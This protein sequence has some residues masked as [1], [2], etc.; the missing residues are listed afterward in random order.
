MTIQI[1]I[2]STIATLK[3]RHE[4]REAMKELRTFS[5]KA[6]QDIGIGRCEIER[7]VRFPLGNGC[8]RLWRGHFQ[9]RQR[10]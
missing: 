3:R 6:L 9:R 5:D 8:T 10:A 1:W 4:E 7:V 2:N